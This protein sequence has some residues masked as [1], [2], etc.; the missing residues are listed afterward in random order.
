MAIA[1]P[2]FKEMDIAK[3]RQYAGHLNLQLAR[4]DSK[5]D[6]IDKI[7]SKLKNKQM[8][9]LADD[10]NGVPPG[11]AEITVL[12]DPM[13]GA[14]NLP[15]FMNANGYQCTIPRGVKVIVPMRVVRTLN[16]AIAHRR[17]QKE[18]KPG[19]P[20]NEI[21]QPTLSYPFQIHNM[22]PGPEPKTKLEEAKAKTMGP[23]RAYRDLFGHW[24]KPHELR[25]AITEGL[26]TL[27]RNDKLQDGT[28]T[29]KVD[30][31]SQD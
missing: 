18:S 15:V 28:A 2:N 21:I 29:L 14:E 24:P 10:V 1:T 9:P 22:T 23:R 6:I 19:I 3:L 16:D 4:T 27:G 8:A 26:V 17:V 5:D 7:E 13:P 11:H 12:Q 25:R 30:E 20:I 31:F